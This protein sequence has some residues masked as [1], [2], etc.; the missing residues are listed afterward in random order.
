MDEDRGTRRRKLFADSS[1]DTNDDN[2]L[3][4]YGN[5]RLGQR[6]VRE[7]VY[8]LVERMI[9]YFTTIHFQKESVFLKQS[10]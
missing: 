5:I 2:M 6:T 9:K 1:V 7:D 8:K 10:V 4:K 3:D